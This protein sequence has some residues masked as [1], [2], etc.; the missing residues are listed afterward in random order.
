MAEPGPPDAQRLTRFVQVLRRQHTRPEAMA[1]F[2]SGVG[3]SGVVAVLAEVAF[4]PGR[5]DVTGW[6]DLPELVRRGLHRAARWPD[7][8]AHGFGADLAALL[9][10]GDEGIRATVSA[11]TAFL[12]TSGDYDARLLAGWSDAYERIALPADRPLTWAS[13]LVG[14]DGPQPWSALAGVARRETADQDR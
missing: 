13:F 7:F 2:F 14:D 1:G 8:D 10:D 9:E 3:A 5:E 11:V 6:D 4:G 12:L